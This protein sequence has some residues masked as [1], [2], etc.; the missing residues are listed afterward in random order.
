MAKTSVNTK[1]VYI[2]CIY[3]PIVYYYF[4]KYTEIPTYF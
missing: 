1:F 3:Q 2:L 4:K